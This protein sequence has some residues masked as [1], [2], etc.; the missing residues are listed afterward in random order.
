MKLSY[1]GWQNGSER[2]RDRDSDGEFFGFLEKG[3]RRGIQ[4]NK[5]EWFINEQTKET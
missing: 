3:K 5:D 1:V 4:I 2:D